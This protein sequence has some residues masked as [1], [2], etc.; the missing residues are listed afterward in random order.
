V[1]LEPILVMGRSSHFIPNNVQKK[2]QFIE[3]KYNLLQ[4]KQGIYNWLK[5]DYYNVNKMPIENMIKI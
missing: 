1:W 3:K 2:V 4:C 5:Y